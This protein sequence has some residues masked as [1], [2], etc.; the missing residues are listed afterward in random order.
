M[1]LKRLWLKTSQREN[2][3]PGVGSREGLK[4]DEYKQT[5]T[6]TRHN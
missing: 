1:Y 6:K 4:E 2:R 3:Y 5:H